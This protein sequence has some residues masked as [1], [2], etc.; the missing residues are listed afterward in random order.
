ME[1]NL[2]VFDNS[3]LVSVKNCDFETD[4]V[5]ISCEINDEG[6]CQHSGL[7][8]SYDESIYYLHFTGKEVRLEDLSNTAESFESIY[9]KK[10][11]II[12]EDDVVSFLG[13][14]QK[15]KNKGVN[16]EYGFVFNDSYYDST[17]KQS[18]LLNAEHDITTCVGFCIKVIRGFIFNNDEYLKLEDWDENSLEAVEHWLFDYVKKYLQIYAD[19]NGVSVED[20]YSNNEL[21]RILPSELLSSTYFIELPIPK[22][23]IDTIRPHLEKNLI[24][25]KVA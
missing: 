21:K 16:P 10:L 15:L 14:C 18:F 8:I 5:A 22:S 12:V 3:S 1:N 25:K 4:F 17:T 19:K 13:H 2:E 23:E 9:I 11:E 7:I 24:A 20:L 6:F